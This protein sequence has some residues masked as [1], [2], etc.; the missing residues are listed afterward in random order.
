MLKFG[1]M[2]VITLLPVAAQET[3]EQTGEAERVQHPERV[4]DKRDPIWYPGDT[5]RVKP[6]TRKL[7][8]N[9]LRHAGQ[10][11]KRTHTTAPGS[12]FIHNSIGPMP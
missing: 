9:I 10:S 6:L 3:Q 4:E 12:L 7:F 5:E 11:N 8:G 2:F 1:L